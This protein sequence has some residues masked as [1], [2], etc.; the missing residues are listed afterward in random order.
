MRD[1]VSLER[2]GTPAMRP[3]VSARR[4]LRD[5]PSKLHEIK[6]HQP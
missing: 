2:P 5:R 6:D 4:A 1:P 3:G